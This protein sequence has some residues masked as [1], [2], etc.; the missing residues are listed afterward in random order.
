[1]LFIYICVLVLHM[2][3]QYFYNVF[4]MNKSV[5]TADRENEFSD[6]KQLFLVK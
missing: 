5:L 2:F 4:K 3:L 6:H 1:M